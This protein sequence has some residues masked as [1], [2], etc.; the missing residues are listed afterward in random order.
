MARPIRSLPAA[1]VR[2]V[3]VTGS[4]IPPPTPW[5]TRN[6]T[7]EGSDQAT[8]H[9]IEP[10]MNVATASIQVVRAP[11]RSETHPET[12]ITATKASRYPVEIHWVYATEASKVERRWSRAMLTIVVSSSVVSAPRTSTRLIRVSRRS[13]T[14]CGP[15]GVEVG[16]RRHYTV[17]CS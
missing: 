2:I 8:P 7:S 5:S 12:G 14:G 15:G 13:E 17:S 11:R 16:M 4:T 10:T 9:S 1:R 6:P 3:I